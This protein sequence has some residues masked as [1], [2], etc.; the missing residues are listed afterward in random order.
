MTRAISLLATALL[1]GCATTTPP[2]FT[3]TNPAS[4]KA[5]ESA[6][7]ARTTSLRDDETTRKTNAM[8][9]A[10]RKD[11]EYWDAYGPVSGTPEDAPKAEGKMDM[12]HEH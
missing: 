11:Q 3:A 2:P 8:L 9:S 7:V 6:R 12:K 1:T 5:P 4:P 10:A